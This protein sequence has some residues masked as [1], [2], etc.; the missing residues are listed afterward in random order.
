MV[1]SP[2]LL[3]T[4]VILVER[5]PKY[6]DSS[7]RPIVPHLEK[8]NPPESFMLVPPGT[9]CHNSQT[10]GKVTHHCKNSDHRLFSTDIRI[11]GPRA[12]N[13]EYSNHDF[14]NL[15]AIAVQVKNLLHRYPEHLRLDDNGAQSILDDLQTV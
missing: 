9:N 10:F 14:S 1:Y 15:E 12:E 6:T 13:E 3:D 7:G 2:T 5:R 8:T 4:D 11:P